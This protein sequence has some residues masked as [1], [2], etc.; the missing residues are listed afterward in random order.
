M[1]IVTESI[2]DELEQIFVGAISDKSDAEI[3]ALAENVREMLDFD[4][5]QE[6]V[7]APFSGWDEAMVFVYQLDELIDRLD[8]NS[9]S[10]DLAD[11][12][13]DSLSVLF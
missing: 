9:D 6:N 7:P 3:L 13:A 2:I 8:R 12:Q 4:L 10:R 5:I 11:T 1:I